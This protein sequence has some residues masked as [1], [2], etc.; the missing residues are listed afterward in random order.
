MA[1]TFTKETNGNVTVRE[2]GAVVKVDEATA[3]KEARLC[4]VVYGALELGTRDYMRKNGFKKVLL[5]LSG[6]IDSSVVA[7]IAVDALGSEKR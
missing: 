2:G 3:P 6:G 7:A 4:E 5:G 1:L